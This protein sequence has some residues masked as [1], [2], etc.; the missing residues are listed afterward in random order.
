[1]ASG[2]YLETLKQAGFFSF[3]NTQFLGA[4]NDNFLKIVVSFVALNLATKNS[5]GYVELIAFLFILPSALFSGYAGHLADVYSKRTI[6]VAVKVFEI[7]IMLFVLGAFFVGHIQPMLAA[8]FLMGLHAAFFSPAKYGILPEMLPEK[9]LSRGNGLLEMSTFMA[10]ILGTALGGAIFAVWK[11]NLALIG[12][13]MIA[14]AIVGYF[15]SLGITRVPP[16]GA[17]KRFLLNPLAEIWDGTK[18]L[19]RD[20]PLWL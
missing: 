17:S 13:A 5:D 7:V 2:K 1:M 6:L 9:D 11:H 10:I 18:R 19:Y 16:S 20:R 12:I 15:T 8:V 14:I 4:F 3:F